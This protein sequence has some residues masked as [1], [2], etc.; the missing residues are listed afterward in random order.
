MAVPL[1]KDAKLYFS[2]TNLDDDTNT[3]DDVA[4]EEYSNVVDLSGN[5]DADSIDATTR[6]TAQSGFSAEIFTTNRGE[7]TFGMHW[8]PGDEIFEAIKDA[9]LLKTFVAFWVANGDKDEGAEGIAANWSVSMRLAQPVK[10]I[11][12]WDVTL[13]VADTVSWHDTTGS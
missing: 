6:A 5:F 3:A 12:T 4:W 11:Q 10:G 9:W 13:R 1:G 7:V 8:L 2:D